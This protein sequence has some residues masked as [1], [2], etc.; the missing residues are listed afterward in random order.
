MVTTGSLVKE[1]VAIDDAV[2]D[3]DEGNIG[4]NW[5][6][7]IDVDDTSDKSCDVSDDED[8]DGNGDGAD[9]EV[10]DDEDE[11]VNVDDNDGGDND[12]GDND[13]ND[14]NDDATFDFKDGSGV[15][16]DAS[17][18]KDG[19]DA[20]GVQTIDDSDVDDTED[21]FNDDDDSS[22]DDDETYDKDNSDTLSIPVEI[23][24]SLS[25][26][27]TTRLSLPMILIVQVSTSSPPYL[28]MM[29][30][31]FPFAAQ[32]LV[33]RGRI[34]LEDLEKSAAAVHASL[35]IKT[36]SKTESYLL[37]VYKL[38]DQTINKVE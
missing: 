30:R 29:F 33:D 16:D 17:E 23:R 8:D 10:D 2:G 26:T 32:T 38:S 37:I 25:Y 4:L 21:D 20:E 1:V 34:T 3:N 13:D 18:D 11:C 28:K 31:S 22:S 19:V 7:D 15:S 35:T 9:H 6:D 14:D 5:D 24:T 36:N 27:F 12:D